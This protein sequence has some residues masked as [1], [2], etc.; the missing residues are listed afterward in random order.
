MQLGIGRIS[1]SMP[2]CEDYPC[3]GHDF[4]QCPDFKERLGCTTCGRAL[5]I[6]A[7]ASLCERCASRICGNDQRVVRMFEFH[8]N[9]GE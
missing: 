2:R 7:K 5:P 4:N 1:I 6:D 9:G 3:C 8:F